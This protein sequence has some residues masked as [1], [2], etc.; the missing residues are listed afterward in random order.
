MNS[1]FFS[2]PCPLFLTPCRSASKHFYSKLS[3]FRMVFLPGFLIPP[4]FVEHLGFQVGP[5]LLEP[6]F[7][8]RFPAK[9]GQCFR[10]VP[11][12]QEVLRLAAAA[13]TGLAGT[14]K[15][16][17]VMEKQIELSFSQTGP[18]KGDSFPYGAELPCLIRRVLPDFHDAALPEFSK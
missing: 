18:R 2:A 12:K 3:R 15:M 14:G 1:H 17:A 7:P 13:D 9:T 16:F 11:A 4:E 8:L 5:G 10:D 6:L